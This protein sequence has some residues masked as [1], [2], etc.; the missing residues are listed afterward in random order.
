MLK[1]VYVSPLLLWMGALYFCLRVMMTEAANV[2][3]NA[4]GELRDQYAKWVEKKQEQLEYAFW[5]LF[6]GML[7]AMGLVVLRGQW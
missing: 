1:I 6:C 2:D 7:D 3:L 5:W 4:P